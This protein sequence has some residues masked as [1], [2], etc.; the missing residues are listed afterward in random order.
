MGDQPVDLFLRPWKGLVGK[1]HLPIALIRQEKPG[2]VLADEPPQPL[3][4][5]QQLKLSPQVHQ[6][7]GGGRAGQAHDALDA[8]PHLQ[9]CAEPLGLVAFEGGQLIDDHHVIV[10]R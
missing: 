8:G 6:P 5:I 7:I 10:E 4:H 3:P 2:A 1:H 9:Q